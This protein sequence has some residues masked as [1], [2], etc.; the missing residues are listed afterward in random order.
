MTKLLLPMMEILEAATIVSVSSAAHYAT[1]EVWTDL[2]TLNNPT[3]YKVYLRHYA[4]SVYR[5]FIHY[6]SLRIPE[7]L[8]NIFFAQ[9]LHTQLRERGLDNIF[10]NSVHPGVVLTDLTRQYGLPQF[11]GAIAEWLTENDLWVW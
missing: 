8:A 3:W 10:V 1:N 9:E 7:K 11:M 4:N 5:A 2:E 6:F